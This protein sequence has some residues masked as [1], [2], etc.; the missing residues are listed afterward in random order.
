MCGRPR[1]A[2]TRN[3]HA[4]DS[5]RIGIALE[6]L[7]T[8]ANIGIDF[9][10]AASR[11]VRAIAKRRRRP[12]DHGPTARA[13]SDHHTRVRYGSIGPA[14]LLHKAAVEGDRPPGPASRAKPGFAAISGARA[15]PRQNRERN[16]DAP[17]LPAR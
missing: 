11:E 8:L 4:M 16:S 13:P 9:T 5:N 17:T 2:L 10:R 12:S 1:T 6:V 15:P 14:R 3:R 7:G